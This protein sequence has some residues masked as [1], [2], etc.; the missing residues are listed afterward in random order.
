MSQCDVDLKFQ[1]K[2]L[3]SKLFGYISKT[4][5][6]VGVDFKI[7]YAFVNTKSQWIKFYFVYANLSPSTYYSFFANSTLQ[8]TAYPQFN[9]ESS[10]RFKVINNGIIPKS[11]LIKLLI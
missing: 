7:D 1:T 9:Y 2:R 4:D 11:V 8:T 10:L 6:S 3:T 5:S